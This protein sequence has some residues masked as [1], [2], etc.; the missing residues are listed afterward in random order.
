MN[1]EQKKDLKSDDHALVRMYNDGFFP[2]EMFKESTETLELW[3]KLEKAE[4]NLEQHLNEDEL[5]LFQEI[6]LKRTEFTSLLLK[7]SFLCYFRMGAQLI[8]DILEQ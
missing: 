8:K 2:Q 3:C 4:Y 5:K 6:I 1:N 7:D